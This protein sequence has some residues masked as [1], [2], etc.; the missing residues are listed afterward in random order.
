M[1]RRGGRRRLALSRHYACGGVA[2]AFGGRTAPR[3]RPRWH[4]PPPALLPLP[5]NFSFQQHC[6]SSPC[7]GPRDGG[8]P[9]CYAPA[10]RPRPNSAPAF[11]P[12]RGAAEG[13]RLCHLI[14][15]ALDSMERT[16]GQRP[17]CGTFRN[18]PS[19]QC[20]NSSM[21]LSACTRLFTLIRSVEELA[22]LSANIACS[23]PAPEAEMVAIW[24]IE[25]P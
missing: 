4:S 15:M 19:A 12:R 18:L 16:A 22:S 17:R 25:Y 20:R 7:P 8:N 13:M 6:S 11:P 5:A 10:P 1:H 3:R 21:M 2:E 14:V 23:L 24:P 9:S